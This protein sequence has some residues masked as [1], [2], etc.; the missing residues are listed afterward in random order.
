MPV[1]VTLGLGTG[2]CLRSSLVRPAVEPVLEVPYSTDAEAD[3]R[4]RSVAASGSKAAAAQAG[5]LIDRDAAGASFATPLTSIATPASFEAGPTALPSVS[6][7]GRSVPS[8]PDPKLEFAPGAATLADGA[9]AA[10]APAGAPPSPPPGQGARAAPANQSPAVSSTPLLDEAMRRVD[11]ITRHQFDAT[12]S[13]DS[14][15]GA[16]SRPAA[17]AAM[18][19]AA[20]S[21]T[22][23]DSPPPLPKVL[24]RT[25]EPAESKE[26]R[27]K[28]GDS[29]HALHHVPQESN[30]SA[31]APDEPRAHRPRERAP[32]SL[33]RA[34]S[35]REQ[36][37]SSDKKETRP[38]GLSTALLSP[39]AKVDDSEKRQSRNDPGTDSRR[40]GPACE[41][42]QRL[43]VGT[44][45]LCRKVNGFGSFEPI[46][47]TAVRAGQQVLLYCEMT[48]VEYQPKEGGYASQLSSRVELRPGD[49]DTV[50]W[51]QELGTADDFC[52]RKRL[53]YY[54]SYRLTI[55]PSLP[56]GSHRLCIVQT[57]LATSRS[58]SAEM[59]VTIAP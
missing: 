28:A 15:G 18:T 34:S 8:P 59:P 45:Q 11:A 29:T 40:A 46:P 4:D 55:P 17:T 43:S 6:T 36:P 2:G 10:S 39:N 54:V 58:A 22:T 32:S 12:N 13:D 5:R 37:K 35:E 14:H 44:L 47:A 56:A 42:K 23:A 38:V 33:L 9:P 50:L 26:A 7:T 30:K 24:G 19:A 21:A 48:G 52:L 51:A 16:I 1:C 57:D 3:T 20:A 25:S 31:H 53:D 27:D 41:E 49:R